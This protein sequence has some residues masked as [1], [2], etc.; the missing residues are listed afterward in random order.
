MKRNRYE[1]FEI[2]PRVEVVNCMKKKTV[3]VVTK[4]LSHIHPF[5]VPLH[6]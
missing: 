4:S 3:E 1:N 6:R 2:R 5:E